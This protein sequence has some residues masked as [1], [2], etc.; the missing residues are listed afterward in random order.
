MAIRN[1]RVVGDD[2]LTKPCKP[3][4]EVKEKTKVLIQDMFDTMYDHDGVGPYER[5]S[6]CFFPIS[7]P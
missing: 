1:V 7:V 6:P 5:L 4:K 3:V 2:I